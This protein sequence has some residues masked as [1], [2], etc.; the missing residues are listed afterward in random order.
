MQQINII[1]RPTCMFCNKLKKLLI[2]KGIPF[3]DHNVTNSE[4]ERW[5]TDKEGNIPVPQVDIN[6]MI[7][8]DY[9]SEEILVENIQKMLT[10]N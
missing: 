5:M 7:I 2:E 6:G 10:S 8:Y 3:K 9:P 4:Q 1:T